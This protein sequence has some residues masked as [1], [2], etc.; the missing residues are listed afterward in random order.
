M[1]DALSIIHSL[2]HNSLKNITAHLL[3][4]RK[5][6]RGRGHGDEQTLTGSLSQ[7]LTVWGTR[8]FSVTFVVT[9]SLVKLQIG[10]HVTAD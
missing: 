5:R 9:Q 8:P 10:Q 2:I 6:A 7:E 4:A 1:Y 3:H